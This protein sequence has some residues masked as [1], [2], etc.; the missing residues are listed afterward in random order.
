MANKARYS[1]YDIY[2]LGSGMVGYR[3]M[4]PETQAALE[5]SEVVYLV[6]GQEVVKEYIEREL[7]ENVVSLVKEYEPEE[8]RTRTYERMAETVLSGAEEADG[9]VSFLLYGHPMIF[10]SP[11]KKILTEAPERGLD[12][13]I[14]PAISSMDCLYTDLELDPAANGIQMFEATDLLLRKFE[15]NPDVPAMLWQIGSLETMLYSTASSKP[16]R[17]TRLREYLEQFYPETH[18]ISLVRTATYP[19]TESERLDFELRNFEQMHDKVNATQT[20]YIPPVRKR[21]VQDEELYQQIQSE[22]HLRKITNP[23][24]NTI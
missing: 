17:F 15:L 6:H 16:E 10:V 2:I 18:T 13:E 11:A 24:E 4:T 21:P 8:Q 23:E 14:L 9:P 20:L 7:T 5:K 12:V 3:Q 22:E 1:P 19:I